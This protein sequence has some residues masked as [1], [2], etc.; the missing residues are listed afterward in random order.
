VKRR[1]AALHGSDATLEVTKSDAAF[2]VELR[3]P[4]FRAGGPAPD[5]QSPLA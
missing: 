4:A 2:R 5:P 1:L 3:L